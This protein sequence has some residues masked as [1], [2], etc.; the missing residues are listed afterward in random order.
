MKIYTKVVLD[1]DGNV[2]E[3]DSYDYDGP[4]AEAKGG[5]GSSTNTIQQADPWSGQQ[6]YLADVMSEAQRLYNTAGPEM[7]SGN[8]VVGYNPLE[9]AAQSYAANYATTGAQ[10]LANTTLAGNQYLASPDLMDPATNAYLAK[11]A[12][13]A[14]DPIFEQLNR[15][16]LPALRAGATMAGHSGGSRRGIAE[17]LAVDSATQNALN[18]TSQIY[19]DAYAQN[20]EALK[21]GVALAPQTI[22]AGTLPSTIL[23][24]VGSAERAYEQ[25]L[26]DDAI[27][28]YE[29]EQQLPFNKLA[30]YQA[31][32][33]GNF[34]GIGSSTSTGTAAGQSTLGTIAGAAGTGLAAYAGMSSIGALAPFAPYAA[35]G[36][37]LAS[38]FS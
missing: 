34:G 15:E 27:R 1:W 24:G 37:A 5:G 3:E 29:Y 19:S 20:L 11:Y 38:L 26:L 35:A 2:L 7:Y 6:P 17:G 14:V 18:T 25:S 36:I 10:D 12:Q 16:T 32:I 4:L 9:Q 8:T 31:L 21:S 33:Q 30:A 28:Q 22:Q 13:G 23:G